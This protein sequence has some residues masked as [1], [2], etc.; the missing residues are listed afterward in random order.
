[1]AKTL[2]KFFCCQ[3]R[4]QVEDALLYLIIKNEANFGVCYHKEW[5]NLRGIRIWSA[6]FYIGGGD[7]KNL[8]I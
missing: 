6:K 4:L 1:M 3:V 5:L 8:L 7:R 2:L